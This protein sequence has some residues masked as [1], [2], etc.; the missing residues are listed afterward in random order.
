MKNF[1][2]ILALL[3]SL[4]M[5]LTAFTACSDSKKSSDKD[6]DNKEKITAEKSTLSSDFIHNSNVNNAN[7]QEDGEIPD[8][9]IRTLVMATNTD[10]PPY[11]YYQ[12]GLITGI[13]IEIAELIARELGAELEITDMDYNG[14]IG[15]VQN[16]TADFGMAGIAVTAD[17]SERV[18]F[19]DSY[20]T[21]TQMIVVMQGS[22]ISGAEDLYGKK[23]GVVADSTADV[24]VTYDYGE[25]CAVRCRRSADVLMELK[26]GTVDAVIV[27]DTVAER[28][29]LDNDSIAVIG[30]PYVEE[31]Y[32]IAVAKENTELLNQ[33]N[34]A[35]AKLERE[36]KIQAIADKYIK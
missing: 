24:Y 33:I 4:L 27:S 35:I 21:N 15:A 14:I 16:G 12:G 20:I 22:D 36:G 19:T 7:G 23:I 11:E 26:S 3:V 28:W 10:F 17:R 25:D 30:T 1:K 2:R 18:D 29:M 34:A 32:A 5:I 31:E 6:D 9:E 8:T 13:D